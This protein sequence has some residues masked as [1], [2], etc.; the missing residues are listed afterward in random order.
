MDDNYYFANIEEVTEEN[1]NYREVLFTTPTQQLVVMSI[2][3]GEE[4][5]M[6][7]HP[8]TTQ[9]VRVEEGTGIVIIGDMEGELG[10]GDCVVI[11]PNTDH[12]VIATTTL[13]LYTI[14]SPPEHDKNLVQEN[15]N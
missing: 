3:E 5:G 15:K 2:P 1:N 10:P 6:E 7:R 8:L 11:P 9:F 13:K 4:I 12:N 14:Y